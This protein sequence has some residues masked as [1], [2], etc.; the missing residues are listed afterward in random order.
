[1]PS[2]EEDEGK[3]GPSIEL[4]ESQIIK[5]YKDLVRDL[6]ETVDQVIKFSDG[7]TECVDKENTKIIPL[8]IRLNQG[9]SEPVERV[10][11]DSNTNALASLNKLFS[12]HLSSL[13]LSLDLTN[14]LKDLVV[15]GYSI[16]EQE[17]RNGLNDV[18]LV[19][20]NLNT[21]FNNN[22]TLMSKF[23]VQNMIDIKATWLSKGTTKEETC[24]F[25]TIPPLDTP[26]ALH[27]RGFFHVLDLPAGETSIPDE[28]STPEMDFLYSVHLYVSM[29]REV[30]G[31]SEE[32]RK[33][34][35]KTAEDRLPLEAFSN[36]NQKKWLNEKQTMLQGI[37]DQMS[38]PTLTQDK[39]TLLENLVH[40][41]PCFYPGEEKVPLIYCHE[42]VNTLVADIHMYTGPQ[43]GVR[44]C[45]F[46]LKKLK[47][48]RLVSVECV[49]IQKI[50]QE[51]VFYVKLAL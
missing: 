20:G 26:F 5:Q 29:F 45:S 50:R 6:K 42:H 44:A 51:P 11:R 14:K 24:C 48:A 16:I 38:N 30:P 41:L 33:T 46:H 2:D 7:I 36:P 4:L 37:H 47:E 35:L 17:H 1:M 19:L 10:I 31:L 39:K 40:E 13:S 32:E 18:A 22:F 23:F 27:Q 9:I 43:L 34:Q 28:I 15:N 8:V 3:K 25:K 49:E 12:D 21:T